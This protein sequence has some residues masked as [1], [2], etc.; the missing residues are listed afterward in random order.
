MEWRYFGRTAG[1]D[2]ILEIYRCPS[3]GKSL[4]EQDE[5]AI[6]RIRRSGS[7]EFDPIGERAIANEEATGW[8]DEE[9]NE[10][11]EDE[12]NELIEKWRQNSWPGRE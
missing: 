12:A 4:F 2:R 6:Q 8:F 9:T 5:R 10:I 1:L 11:S 7:W 3:N